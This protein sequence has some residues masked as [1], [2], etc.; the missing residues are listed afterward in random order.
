MIQLI[1]SLLNKF[2]LNVYS[3]LNIRCVLF[4]HTR[5]HEINYKESTKV[6]LALKEAI[7]YSNLEICSRYEIICKSNI[8]EL[9]KRNRVIPLTAFNTHQRLLV[10][11]SPF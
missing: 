4:L 3:N 2:F 11:H 1:F 6:I 5:T 9:E 10:K 7:F 8:K